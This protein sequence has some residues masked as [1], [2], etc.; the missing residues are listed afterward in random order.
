MSVF[1]D[2]SVFINKECNK[3]APLSLKCSVSWILAL[4]VVALVTIGYSMRNSEYFAA[5]VVILVMVLAAYLLLI[6]PPLWQLCK[7][8][9][10]FWSWF[11]LLALIILA[12]LREYLLK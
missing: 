12:A 7:S 3:G 4:V 9:K 10:Y 6:I 1:I 2:E 11:P 8:E 5:S